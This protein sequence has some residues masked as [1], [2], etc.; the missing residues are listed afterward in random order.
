MKSKQPKKRFGLDLKADAA[1]EN[2]VKEFD[3]A[4]QRI[5]QIEAKARKSGTGGKNHSENGK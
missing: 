4:R 5:R 1:L 2:V 3:L